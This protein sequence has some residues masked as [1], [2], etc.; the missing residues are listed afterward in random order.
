MVR[1]VKTDNLT[2]ILQELSRLTGK[3]Y[4]DVV[5]AELGAILSTSVRNT[6]AASLESINKTRDPEW[7][8][9]KIAAIGLQKKVFVQIGDKLGIS[10]DHP[11]YVARAAAPSGDHP[12]DAEGKETASGK[13]FSLDCVS[14]R[15]YDPTVFSVV[16]KAINGRASFFRRNLRKGVFESMDKMAA[17][18]KRLFTVHVD[19]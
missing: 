13:K 18:Y 1:I 15:F 17:K 9:Q 19:P 10:V 7:R 16:A 3:E 5:R 8:A 14:H 11:Q 12:E 2:P 4:R 6:A